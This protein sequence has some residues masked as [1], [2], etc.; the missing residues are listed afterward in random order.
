[1]KNAAP[2]PGH[3]ETGTLQRASMTAPLKAALAREALALGFDCIG[4][5]DPAAIGDA[6]KHFHAFIEAGGHGDMDWLAARPERRADP[7]VLWPGCAL[8]HHA[9]R[10]LRAR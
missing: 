10:Q 9:R 8:H 4:V 3:V 2:R 1:M 6:G 5:T 7:R